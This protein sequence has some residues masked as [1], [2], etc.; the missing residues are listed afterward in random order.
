[1]VCITFSGIKDSV[2]LIDL[3]VLY[4]QKKQSPFYGKAL[5]MCEGQ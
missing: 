4:N 5:H 1:M 2:V 3:K